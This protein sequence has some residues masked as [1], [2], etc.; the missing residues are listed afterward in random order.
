MSLAG[1][2]RSAIG[3]GILVSPSAAAERSVSSV[4]AGIGSENA[5]AAGAAVRLESVSA[6]SSHNS[7]VVFHKLCSQPKHGVVSSACSIK[8]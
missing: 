7:T 5:G 8:L 6:P 4:G 3:C 2:G 1:G